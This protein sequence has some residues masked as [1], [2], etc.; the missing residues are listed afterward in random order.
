MTS[1]PRDIS[2]R[3]GGPATRPG[4]TD[5]SSSGTSSEI[6][7]DAKA[8]RQ[9]AKDAAESVKSKAAG[10]GAEAK[11][12]A[13]DTADDVKQQARSFAEEQKEEVAGRVDGVADALRSAAGDFDGQDQSAMAGYAREAAKGLDQV[14]TALSSR[15]LDDLVGTVEDFA[16][17]QP[18]A[19]LGGAALAGFV[20]ARFAKSS[21]DRRHSDQ[22]RLYAGSRDGA[23]PQHDG[24]NPVGMAGKDA[25]SPSLPNPSRRE[26]G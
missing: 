12:A 15:N 22:R 7:R 26:I 13:R 1:D 3:P 18:I 20:L 5:A 4:M 11:N 23:D 8:T 2:Q 19:F 25:N 16:R 10:L 21:S 17:R 9:A 6:E 24:Y 14:S